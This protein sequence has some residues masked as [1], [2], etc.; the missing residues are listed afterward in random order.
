MT[1]SHSSAASSGSLPAP[2]AHHTPSNARPRMALVSGPTTAMRNSWDA[3][4]DSCAI[5]ETPPRMNSVMLRTGMPY[6]RATMLCANS[7]KR[8]DVKNRIAVTTDSAQAVTLEGSG[9]IAS[10][11]TCVPRITVNRA[12]EIKNEKSRMMGIPIMRAMRTPPM[13]RTDGPPSVGL[14]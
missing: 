13:E 11:K 1:P 12:R 7:C 5:C 6:R 3:R 9:S 4:E 8:M 14:L 10:G 2:I